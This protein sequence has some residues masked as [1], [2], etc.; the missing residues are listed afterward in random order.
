MK[1]REFTVYL[2]ALILIASTS[3]ASASTYRF[4]YP[5]KG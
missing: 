5:F 3:V 4:I 2:L 1:Y